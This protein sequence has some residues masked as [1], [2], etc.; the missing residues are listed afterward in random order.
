MPGPRLLDDHLV[1]RPPVH[2][3]IDAVGEEDGL[4]DIMGNEQ[5]G[6][7]DLIHDLQIP[8]VHRAFGQGIQGGEGLV[9]QGHIL[10]EQVGSQQGGPLAHTAG[11]LGGPQLF[12]PLQTKLGE[13]GGGLGPGLLL[14][15]PPQQQGQSHVVLNGAVGQQQVLLQH[16]ADLPRLSRHVLAVQEHLALIGTEQTGNDVEQGGLAAAAHAQQ[17]DQLPLPQGEGDVPQHGLAVKG[18]A[19]MAY[20]QLF[21]GQA[22]GR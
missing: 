19:H 21:H 1:L 5:G 10:G 7:T 17:A 14:L 3:E 9:Q 18:Q 4:V 13:Q 8:L 20:F 6:Q 16:V 11:E 22:A 15:H 2:E 12:R